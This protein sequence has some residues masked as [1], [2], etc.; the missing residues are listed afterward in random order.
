MAKQPQSSPSDHLDAKNFDITDEKR[1]KFFSKDDIIFQEGHPGYEAYYIKKGTVNIY[2]LS[3]N[4]RILLACLQPGEI[5]GEMSILSGE[6]RNANAVANEDVTLVVIEKDIL[7]SSMNGTLPMVQSLAISLIKRLNNSNRKINEKP[8]NNTLLSVCTVLHLLFEKMN[9]TRSAFV[10][11]SP[12]NGI[13]YYELCKTIKDIVPLTEV[14]ID[15][16][17]DHL[18]RHAYIKIFSEKTEN[19]QLSK[20]IV[21]DDPQEFNSMIH[22]VKSS[23]GWVM[24]NDPFIQDQE[25]MD[26]FDFAQM[27]N[28]SPDELIN[29]FEH[30]DIP[31]NLLF[32]HRAGAVSWM[33]N[34]Q[35]KKIYRRLY[36]SPFNETKQDKTW[37]A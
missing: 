15:Y 8:S 18:V 22:K 32:L 19:G 17:L 24:E 1:L 5:F 12:K 26:L 29:M 16:V 23:G 30:E 35:K 14:D 13:R 6:V 34:K 10:G 21:I 7:T 11:D 2:R 37:V 4:K 20:L 9:A 31:Q 25:F 28:T 3:S 36:D 27:M 33:E